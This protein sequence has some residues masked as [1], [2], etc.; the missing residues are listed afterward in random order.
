MTIGQRNNNPL[1]IRRVK[2]QKWK[3]EA[4]PQPSPVGEGALP[5]GGSGN[6]ALPQGGSGNVSSPSGEVG[7]GVLEVGRGVL[8]GTGEAPGPFV[9]FSSL[10]YGL[11][12]AFCI[13]RTY[14]NKYKAVCIED[15]ITRWAPPTEND[16][17][18]YISDVCKLT[19][20]GGKERLT[21]NDWPRLV[22]A[23]ARLESGMKLTEEQ[24][25]QGFRLYREN[26]K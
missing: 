9:R 22:G 13:L 7:R 21:E 15:I 3:G 24:I 17:R 20:F 4:S 5:Q 14:R 8:E 11:R 6:G 19:G 25:R 16:T 10:T 12:A 2:G 18:K 26:S 1:N 23:M